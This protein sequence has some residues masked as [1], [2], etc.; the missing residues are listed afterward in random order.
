VSPRP[1][2]EVLDTLRAAGF[3]PVAEGPDGQVVDL[4]AAG[5]RVPARP[6][7]VRQQMPAGL[8]A[9]RAASLVRQLRAG[10]AAASVR[11]GPAVRPGTADLAGTAA[12]MALLRGAAQQRRSVWIGYV[13]AYGVA[14]RRIVEPVSASGGTLE[15]FD[16]AHGGLRRVPLHRITSAAMVDD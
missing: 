3:A 12:T 2:A 13:D 7:L 16:S 10:D 15:C 8:D 9:E 1:L 6:R 11:H 14:T 5:R 4:R